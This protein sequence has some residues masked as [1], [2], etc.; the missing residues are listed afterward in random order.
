[1]VVPIPEVSLKQPKKIEKTK[2][3]GDSVTPAI[4]MMATT[5]EYF[6]RWD[7]CRVLNPEVTL[8]A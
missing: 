2:Q 4:V 5:K 3:G 1:M 8:E 6:V 7:V